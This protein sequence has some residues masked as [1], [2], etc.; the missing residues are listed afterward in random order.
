MSRVVFT[1]RSVP[2]FGG[3]APLQNI[4]ATA[5][6]AGAPR[7]QVDKCIYIEKEGYT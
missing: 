5:Q 3:F 6:L 1:V 4:R 7:F 2:Q